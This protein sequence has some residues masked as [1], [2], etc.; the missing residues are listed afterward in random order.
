MYSKIIVFFL[1]IFLG[2]FLKK[3]FEGKPEKVGIKN[4][5]LNI[6]LPATIF[7]SFVSFKVHLEYIFLPLVGIAFNIFIFLI[8]P[9]ILRLAQ[10]Q[11]DSQKGRT[12]FML[13]SSF[14]PGISCFPIIDEFLGS[15]FL[16]KASLL[17]FG[18]KIFVLVFLLGF[19]FHL[20]RITQGIKKKKNKVSLKSI[21]KN[22]FFEPINIVLVVSVSM[23]ILGY[24]LN[25]LPRILIN[26]VT[27][28]KETL[29]PL[30][31]I[32]VGLSIMFTKDAVKE[33]I[34][35]LLLRAGICL[36][37]TTA[38]IRLF[39]INDA[40]EITFLLL[41]SLSAVSFWPFAH[42]TLI[43]N[44]EKKA[45]V[46][47][48]TFDIGFGLNFLAYSLP[49]STVT[50]L[51]FLSNSGRVTSPSYLFSVSIVMLVLGLLLLYAGSIT[52]NKKIISTEKKKKWNLTYFIKTFL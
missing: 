31:L 27:R 49:F 43:D 42:M 34:P 33:I 11:R 5:I 51:L 29:S 18:N 4:F 30:V 12:L 26:F 15:E 41:L 1:L 48:K 9:L 50:I 19:S 2:I 25:D 38:M 17:D 3:K 10:I 20:H 36:L 40:N 13:L 28:L 23:L 39:N 46:E 21:L 16:I 22:I 45:K 24:N 47:K 6:S 14:A 52:S 44:M 8:S 35:L 32:F 7:I 37:I